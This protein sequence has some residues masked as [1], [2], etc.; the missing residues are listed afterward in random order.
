MEGACGLGGDGTGSGD[1]SVRSHS[2]L[3]LRPLGSREVLGALKTRKTVAKLWNECAS[4]VLASLRMVPSSWAQWSVDK[5]WDSLSLDVANSQHKALGHYGFTQLFLCL[6]LHT[7]FYM[8]LLSC[9]FSCPFGIFPLPCDNGL[10]KRGTWL[11]LR[12]GTS[13]GSHQIS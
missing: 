5:T 8:M 13:K 10:E 4:P 9:G 11:S 3:I 1:S 6:D 12:E 7:G 2:V